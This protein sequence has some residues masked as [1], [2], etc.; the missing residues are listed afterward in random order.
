[1]ISSYLKLSLTA[2][3]ANKMRTLLTTIGIVIGMMMVIVVFSLGHATQAIVTA[4]LESYGAN[5]IVVEVKTPGVSEMSPGSATAMMEGVTVATL[6]EED[7]EDAF[8]IPGVTDGYAAVM[9]LERIVSV[10]DD[11]QYMIQGVS[12]SFIDIDQ[13]D[14]EYGRFFTASEDK[15]LARVVVLG[16]G[17]AEELFPDVDPLGQSVRIGELNF[18]I[19]GVMESLGVVFFQN[20]DDMVYLPLNT[21]QKLI[22]GIDYV[23]YFLL[24]VENE[25]MVEAIKNDVIAL[26]DQRHDIVGEDKRDFRVTTMDEAISMMDGVTGAL[27][28]LL[29]VLAG[30]SLVVGGVG[31]MNVMFVAVTE[32]TREIGLRKAVGA[33][34]RAVLCQFLCES[35]LVT[36]VGGVLGILLG[37][38]VVWLSV[39]VAGLVGVEIEFF[40]PVGGII[41]AI[42]AA[43]AEGILFGVYP[44]KKAAG[45]NPIES[46]RYE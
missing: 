33:T 16:K 2:L 5:T 7:M 14:V 36:F 17:V 12:A 21:T 25:E 6:K 13:S 28:I 20:M 38:M 4:Q 43:F 37:L 23:P 46:L 45:L 9:G 44:A 8:L 10:Y 31:V 41:L 19:I 15:S 40:V 35:V 24:Q 1:M 30:I 18:K 39:V 22:M 32:R 11:Q 34:S 26:L 3:R 27:Q 42:G 29:I